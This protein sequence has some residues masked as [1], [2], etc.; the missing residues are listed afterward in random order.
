[1]SLPT[2]DAPMSHH[3]RVLSAPLISNRAPEQ[4]GEDRTLRICLIASEYAGI[5]RWGGFGVLTRDLAAALAARG[6]DVYVVMPLKPTQRPVTTMAGVQVVGVRVP[7][8]RGFR[9]AKAYAGV[10]RAIDADIYHSQD[11]TVL[12][13]VAEY[14]AP[15]RKHVVTF[16]DPRTIEDWRKQWV[17]R[18]RNGLEEWSFRFKYWKDIV[19]GIHRADACFCQ[20]RCIIE[21]S[22]A[23]YGLSRAPGFLPNPVACPTT[24]PVKSVEPSVCF[25]GRWENI[26]RPELFVDLAAR[27][28][29]VQFTLAGSCAG[30]PA[31]DAQIHRR[32][33]DLPNVYA[34][35]WIGPES[36]G[37]LLGKSWILIN[38]STKECLPV[39][40]LE[41]AAHRCAI[42]SHGNADD[43]ASSFGYWAREGTLDDFAAGLKY[44]LSENRWKQLGARGYEYVSAT[45]NMDS[46]IDLHLRTYE[47]VLAA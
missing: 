44:L 1:M 43:F 13:R 34:P 11:P 9:K 47:Q 31:R 20:A 3:S 46:V 24:E 38:T 42:L 21:R 27:F 25:V 14:A 6:H 32:A 16:Q 8:Y 41:A 7:T 40:Y 10:F 26:K 28:P 18:V 45:H 35:G 37:E 39:S 19:P 12:T 22:M 2:L 15:R 29:E 36:R 23:L 17:P 33:R 30:D 5:D 4:A